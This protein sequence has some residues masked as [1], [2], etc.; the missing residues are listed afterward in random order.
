MKEQRII[1]RLDE[2][3]DELGITKLSISKQ[4]DIRTSTMSDL[5]VNKQNV[6][7][8]RIDTLERIINALNTLQDD[9]VFTLSDIVESVEIQSTD[10]VED[11]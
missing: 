2:I 11:E 3:I 8:L 1:I 10:L 9:K 7:S 4:A 5:T 6:R